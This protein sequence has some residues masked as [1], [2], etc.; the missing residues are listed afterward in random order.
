MG[1]TEDQSHGQ[2]GQ[3]RARRHLQQ[4]P[5]VSHCS[6]CLFRIHETLTKLQQDQLDKLRQ[7]LTDTEDRI[8]QL[9]SHQ[10]PDNLAS[11]VRMLEEHEGLQRDLEAQQEYVN[12]ISSMVVIVDE[13]SGKASSSLLVPTRSS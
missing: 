6:F 7:W 13:T 1:A 12:A 9:A 5:R 3:V 11:A 10:H 4:W 8:S 2:A